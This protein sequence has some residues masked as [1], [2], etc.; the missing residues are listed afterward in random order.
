MQALQP[1]VMHNTD[2]RD[3]RRGYTLVELMTSVI[4]LAILTGVSL[5]FFRDAV[6]VA[7]DRQAIAAANTIN[8]AKK[9][10]EMRVS[11]AASNWTSAANAEA[12]FALI[13]SRIAFSE[14]LTLA[15]FTPTGYTFNLG[16]SIS[17][18]VT[19]TGPSGAVSY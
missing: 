6:P 12:R 15:Q 14:T 8:G 1:S 3:R 18:R 17:D 19:I 16:T 11:T 13:R 2:A 9:A 4:I 5:V 7:Q 10:Y